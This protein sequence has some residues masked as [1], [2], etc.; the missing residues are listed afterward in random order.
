MQ[1]CEYA[2]T[3]RACVR[4]CASPFVFDAYVYRVKA[5]AAAATTGKFVDVTYRPVA[6]CD[7]A[8]CCTLVVAAASPSSWGL[9]KLERSMRRHRS[10]PAHTL[11]CPL[12][13]SAAGLAILHQQ[14][15]E[16]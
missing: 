6:L 15:S 10:M 11:S 12:S 8:L 7:T 9:F 16:F 1:S 13:S 3:V 14:L 4:A 2:C 5:A